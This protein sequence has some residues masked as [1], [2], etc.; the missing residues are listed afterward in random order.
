MSVM[1]D[2]AERLIMWSTELNL[3]PTAYCQR[4]VPGRGVSSVGAEEFPSGERAARNNRFLVIESARRRAKTT[5][6]V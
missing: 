5:S 4:L 6:S 3:A 1:A 2:Y